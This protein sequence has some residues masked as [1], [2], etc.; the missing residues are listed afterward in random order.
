MIRSWLLNAALFAAAA[1]VATPASVPAAQAA[2][3]QADQ[4]QADQ[5]QAH[6]QAR[7]QAPQ[8]PAAQPGQ[9]GGEAA[10]PSPQPVPPTAQQRAAARLLA[11]EALLV[12]THIDVPWRL[13]ERWEDVTQATAGGEFDYPRAVEGGLDVAFMSIYTPAALEAEGGA[14]EM[15]HRLIDSVEAIAA[16]APERFA[17]VRSSA[18]VQRLQR[19]GRVLLALG[20]ENGSPIEGKLDNLRLFHA[21]GVRYVTL[22]HG[23]SNHLADSSYDANRQWDGLSPFGREVVEEMNRLGMMVDVSHLSD[24]AVHDVLEASRAPVIASHS[25]A[26]KFTPGFERNL[27]DALIKA[28]AERGGVVQVNFG[29]AFLTAAAQQWSDAYDAASTRWREE[30]GS[31]GD[32]AAAQQWASAYRKQHPHPYADVPAVADHI[33]HIVGLGGIGSVGIGSDFDGVGD[34]LP[35]GLKSVADFPNLVAELQR[36]DYSEADIRKILGENLMR[37]WRAVEQRAKS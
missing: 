18:D 35:V 30:T 6:Q 17:L 24:A 33:D 3:L 19:H 36:R 26:R 11:H 16:R 7:Q 15:A 37:V 23:K 21:R 12:D 5:H 34:S 9:V 14:R 25:S 27:D 13:F 29:S 28:I 22:A 1:S 2:R 32:D 10:L 8:V 20:M 4:H 31:S